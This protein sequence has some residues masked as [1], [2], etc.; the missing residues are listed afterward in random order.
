MCVFYICMT[1]ERGCRVSDS[2]S[3]TYPSFPPFLVTLVTHDDLLLYLISLYSCDNVFLT[4]RILH[5]TLSL[6]P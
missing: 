3:F 4:C 5:S 6:N 2:F 1:R